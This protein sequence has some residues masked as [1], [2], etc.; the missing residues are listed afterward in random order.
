MEL[1]NE[2]AIENEHVLDDPAPSIIFDA[3]GDNALNLVLRCFVGTQDIRLTTI[4]QL[5][6]AVNEKF[7]AAGI[8]IAFPQRDVHL[9][10]SRPLNVRFRKDD[11]A[12]DAAT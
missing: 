5:H 7:N 2:A 9:D 10:T 3:F 1:M 4:T 11:D 6:E 8:S 12:G